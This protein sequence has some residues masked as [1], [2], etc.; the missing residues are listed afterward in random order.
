MD[1]GTI[2]VLVLSAL[3]L[4]GYF[5]GAQYNRRRIRSLYLWL[6]EG[7]D[8]LGEGQTVKAFGSAGF[9]VHMPKPPA[10]LRDVTLT[11]VLEPRETHLYWLLVRARGRRDVLIFAGKLRRPPSIDLL[12]VDPRVQVGREAL[13]QVA[14]QGWE[15]IP[16]QPEPGLTMAYRGT[17]SSEAAGRFLAA[18]RLV[19]PTVYRLSI[20]REAPHLI[21]T[22]AP[23]FASD[24]SSTA[25]MADWRRLAEMVVER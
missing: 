13:H 14:A 25:M 1:S 20:R 15:V 9:G 4:I 5:A 16:D 10:P 6:R 19:A 23:P 11:L 8:T 24:G 17:V 12:V 21:L 22:V 3:L 7:M 2:F 18:A